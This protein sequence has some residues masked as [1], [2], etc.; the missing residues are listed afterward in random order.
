[1]RSATGEESGSTARITSAFSDHVAAARFG[2]L[3][4]TNGNTPQLRDNRRTLL[5]RGDVDLLPICYQNLAYDARNAQ[6]AHFTM[7]S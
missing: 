7:R 3:G 5:E 2:I 1:M 4:K 6:D